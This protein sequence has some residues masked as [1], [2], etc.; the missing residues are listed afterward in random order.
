MPIKNDPGDSGSA[1]DADH[2]GSH[3]RGVHQRSG[4]KFWNMSPDFS[5]RRALP[6][7]SRLCAKCGSTLRST[8][9][10]WSF[11][12]CPFPDSADTSTDL[13][14]PPYFVITGSLFLH[15]PFLGE[16][17]DWTRYEGR[18][19][20]THYRTSHPWVS[21]ARKWLQVVTVYTSLRFCRNVTPKF[22]SQKRLTKELSSPVTKRSKKLPPHRRQNHQAR[23]SSLA[24]YSSRLLGPMETWV[25]E[26]DLAFLSI[27][28]AFNF[29]F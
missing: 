3:A 1:M 10:R 18:N 7:T 27:Y 22:S 19:C 5:N 25:T 6:T 15:T 29:V 13:F 14:R 8:N 24:S 9:L 4:G 23:S 26:P 16:R 2:D 17:A 28:V 11:G 12:G 20:R 21:Y